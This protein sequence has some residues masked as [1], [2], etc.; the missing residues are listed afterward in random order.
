MRTSTSRDLEHGSEMLG[1]GWLA[2][3]HAA[4]RDPAPYIVN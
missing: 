1:I 2:L 3:T 4:V